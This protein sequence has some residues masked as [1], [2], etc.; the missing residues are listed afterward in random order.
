ML[1]QVASFLK[2]EVCSCIRITS[3]AEVCLVV[4]SQRKWLGTSLDAIAL[5]VD[6]EERSSQS[7]TVDSG[8]SPQF[9]NSVTENKQDVLHCVLITLDLQ[10]V[11]FQLD[12]QT[13]VQWTDLK[14][15]KH[16]RKYV[17]SSLR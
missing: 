5:I 11:K 4:Q 6:A 8:L 1:A 7:S 16:Y 2:D 14:S 10:I 17:L 15:L 9:I 12:C 3:L 13:L